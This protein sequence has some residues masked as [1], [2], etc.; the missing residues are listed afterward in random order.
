MQKYSRRFNGDYMYENV[1]QLINLCLERK[2]KIWQVVLDNEVSISGKSESAVL[3]RFE[4]R[5][6]VMEKSARRALNTPYE[7]AGN[8]ISGIA[9]KQF[10]YAQSSQSVCG[11][12]INRIMAYALSSSEINASMGKICASPTAGSCGIMPAVLL[13]MLEKFNLS[14]ERIIQGMI[15]ASGFGAIVVNNACVSGAQGGC[16]A[17]CGTAAAMSAAA[18]AEMHGG[19]PR[20]CANAFS[21]AFVNCMGL[22]CDPVAGLVQVP[23]AQR[24]ASQAVNALISAD[25]AL[26]GMEL[27]VTADEVVNAMY[28]TGK[29][30]PNKLKET[31][32]GGIADCNSA[33]KIAKNIFSEKTDK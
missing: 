1:E 22:I 5:F 33:K 30:L 10:K 2:Q 26:G 21:I 6:R 13:Y 12:E 20:Q 27:P 24:N 23:C 28:Q 25:L 29:L 7:T 4:H 11:I 8:L 17:E 15:T 9:S 19:T 14:V 18:A 31:A 3:K 16:Q 32:E